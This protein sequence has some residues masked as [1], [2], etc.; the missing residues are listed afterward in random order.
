V[1]TLGGSWVPP[2]ALGG[3]GGGRGVGWCGGG[4]GGVLR[5]GGGGGVFVGAKF[6]HFNSINS[7]FDWGWSELCQGGG[8]GSQTK[9]TFP[10][11]QDF[12]PIPPEQ[13]HQKLNQSSAGGRGGGGGLSGGWCLKQRNGMC[14]GPRI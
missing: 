8:A 6:F 13:T 14:P 2:S 7:F 4:G 10:L 11:P 5:G 9:G 12:L 1:G 3:W